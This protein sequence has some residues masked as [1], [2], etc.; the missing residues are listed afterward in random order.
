MTMR[1]GFYEGE[2]AIAY[3][4]LTKYKVHHSSLAR[5]YHTVKGDSVEAYSG[6]FGKGYKIHSNYW[7]STNYHVV[8][9]IVER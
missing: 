4:D 8:T 7:R 3:F 5:G 2:N 6:K 9:Y 1:T